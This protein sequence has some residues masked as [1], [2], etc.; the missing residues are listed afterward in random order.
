MCEQTSI[1]KHRL[2]AIDDDADSAEL[3]V[4]IAKKAGYE[5]L[6]MLTTGSLKEEISRWR[7]DV[8]TLDLSMP[9]RDGIE[10]LT[11][12]QD[13]GF[14]GQVIVIS[15]HEGW[16]R[17]AASSLAVA[18]GLR[19]AKHFSKPIDLRELCELLADL[20]HTPDSVSPDNASARD[21][22]NI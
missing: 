1:S 16:L 6:P 11:I 14:R 18:R 9:D 20:P 4:R 2:L 12:L 21:E 22:G 8:V 5:A 13:C 10:T 17:E 3:V 7:P 19:I 15:G